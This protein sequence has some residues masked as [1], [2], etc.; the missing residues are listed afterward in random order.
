MKSHKFDA[1]SFISGLV[2]A[3]VGL[4]FLVPQTPVDLIDAVTSL[5]AWFWPVL[6]LAI[7]I[8]VLVPVFMARGHEDEDDFAPLP[9]PERSD[10]LV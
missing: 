3:I 9:D 10:D 2:A 7:G 4:V 1:I 8:A 6:L 5:G